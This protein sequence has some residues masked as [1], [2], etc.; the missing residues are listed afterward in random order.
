MD[1][2]DQSRYFIV[3]VFKSFVQNYASVDNSENQCMIVTTNLIYTDDLRKYL[4]QLISLSFTIIS[5]DSQLL[6]K[7]G[8]SLINVIVKLF[9]KSIEKIGDEEDE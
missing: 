8:F 7:A 9:S 1:L 6:K 5:D 3:K 2:N 4:G